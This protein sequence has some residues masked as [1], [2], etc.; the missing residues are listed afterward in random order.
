MVA[1]AAS[2]PSASV[3]AKS[4]VLLNERS[5]WTYAREKETRVRFIAMPSGQRVY[6]VDPLG[7]FCDCKAATNGLLCAHRIAAMNAT[8]MDRIAELLADEADRLLEDYAF[9]K[10]SDLMFAGFE[11]I[12]V[13][14]APALA[15]PVAR[16]SYQDVDDST[17]NVSAF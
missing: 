2:M 12:E 14:A 17:G 15:A 13:E 3:L 10:E 16:R 6:Q 5:D 1:A 8:S 4:E 7:K 9:Q 11:R